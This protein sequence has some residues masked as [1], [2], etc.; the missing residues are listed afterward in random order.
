V[1]KGFSQ[2]KGVNYF[3][4][5]SP[6]TKIAT[7]R[8]IV[9][10]ATIHGL[11]VHWMNMK[12]ASLNGN[13]VEEIYM[14]RVEGYTTPRQERIKHASLGNLFTAFNKSLNSGMKNL[15]A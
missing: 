9:G 6:V 13:L 3:D 10:L 2:K 4:T 15:I 5:Y 7:I 8:I 1:I 14:Y 12:E 11:L